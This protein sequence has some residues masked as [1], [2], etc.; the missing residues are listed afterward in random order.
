MRRRTVPTSP[1]SPTAPPKTAEPFSPC[2]LLICLTYERAR[3]RSDST[4][5]PDARLGPAWKRVNQWFPVFRIRI[6]RT[7]IADPLCRIAIAHYAE[8]CRVNSVGVLLKQGRGGAN[9]RDAN[10]KAVPLSEDGPSGLTRAER[11]LL[12]VDV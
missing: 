9:T 11:R 8:K 3:E 6:D 12:E 5:A 7:S 2:F 1:T 4:C 10:E